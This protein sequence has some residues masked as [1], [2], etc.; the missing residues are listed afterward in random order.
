V[1]KDEARA[2]MRTALELYRE[3]DK[4]ENQSQVEKLEHWL[5]SH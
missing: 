3:G 4:P 2:S 1:R 5:R